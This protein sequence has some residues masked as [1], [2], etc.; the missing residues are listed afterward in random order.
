[1]RMIIIM[2]L[3]N[4]NNHNHNNDDDDN[5]INY[6]SSLAR[7]FQQT[8]D[9]YEELEN[10]FNPTNDVQYQK[11]I[12]NGIVQLE[13]MTRN[14]NLIG[15]FSVNETVDEV[16]TE[17][18]KYLLLPALLGDFSLRY[19]KFDRLDMLEHGRVYYRD[20]IQ[21]LNDYGIC[22]IELKK[23]DYDDDDDEKG[24]NE[25][26]T[27]E[28]G[29]IKKDPLI[30]SAI[31]RESKIRRFQEAKKLDEKLLQLKR[32]ILEQQTNASHIDEEMER[33]FYLTLIS[34]WLSRAIE[35]LANIDQE[36]PMAKMR[37]SIVASN[38]GNNRQNPS[39]SSS[40]QNKTKSNNKP[41]K[42]I[43]ITRDAT[44]KKVYGLGYPSLPTVTVDEFINQKVTDG[45]LAFNDKRM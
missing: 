26:E 15:L 25:N 19:Q 28:I 20:F 22:D 38:S 39:L 1:M 37:A 31:F 12:Q 30:S 34:R 29:R 18:L 42:P 33:K 43:I 32:L 2:L 24:K 41:L 35:E 40:G 9:L 44:Q 21:R 6:A 36:L 14:V 17:N 27:I 7:D 10:S 4:N 5:K 8:L 13:K 11:K 3:S 16:A 23:N 45:T